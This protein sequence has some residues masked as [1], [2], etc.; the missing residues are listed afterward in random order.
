MMTRLPMM[1]YLSLAFLACSRSI[2]VHNYARLNW[3]ALIPIKEVTLVIV[4]SIFVFILTIV[5]SI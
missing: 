5:K 4:F 2:V 1:I 3:G